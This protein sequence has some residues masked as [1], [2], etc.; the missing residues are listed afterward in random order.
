MT[1]MVAKDDFMLRRYKWKI[2]RL[3]LGTRTDHGKTREL[4]MFSPIW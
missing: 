2:F 4:C 3:V 1:Y